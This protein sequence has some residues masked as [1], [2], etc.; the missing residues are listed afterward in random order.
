MS[1][2]LHQRWHLEMHIEDEYRLTDDAED[3]WLGFIAD[4]GADEIIG[5]DDIASSSY[6]WKYARNLAQHIVDSH[7][8]YLHS[9]P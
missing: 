2:V 9:H 5:F 8:E 7:N 4:E 1:D 6:G 3:C